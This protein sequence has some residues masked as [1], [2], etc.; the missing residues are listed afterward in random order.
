MA[1][2]LS[3]VHSWYNVNFR[4]NTCV[5]TYGLVLFALLLLRTYLPPSIHPRSSLPQMQDQLFRTMEEENRTLLQQVNKLL[6]QNQ[7][8]LVKTL[9]SKDQYLEEG[10]FFQ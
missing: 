8:L 3:S 1:G 7:Q 5:R 9:E 6:E 4:I 2:A 10:K